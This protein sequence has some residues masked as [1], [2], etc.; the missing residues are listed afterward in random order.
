MLLAFSL[1]F[2]LPFGKLHRRN[3]E[4]IQLARRIGRTPDAVAM[5]LVNFAS[6]DPHHQARQVSGLGNAS[7]LDKSIWE[8]FSNNH[9]QLAF[10]CE[11]LYELNQG[12]D[13]PVQEEHVEDDVSHRETERLQTVRT[14]LVQQFF[15]RAVLVGYEHRCA[16][17][18]LGI[19]KL[20]V[21]SHIIP[22]NQNVER[23]ADPSNG[24]AL[25]TIHDRAFD[26]GLIAIHDDL[27]ILLSQELISYEEHPLHRTAFLDIEGKSLTLPTRFIPT[28]ET[29]SYHR[30]HIFVH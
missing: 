19:K 20:L 28:A 7:K 23:R 6:F 21:A 1:Y 16:M 8:E 14:R 24:L 22:W 30:T 26:R 15:R 13:I 27:T 12:N 25:C 4:V 18:G 3:P 17:C 5:K 9:E 10:E 29:L 2:R 11:H